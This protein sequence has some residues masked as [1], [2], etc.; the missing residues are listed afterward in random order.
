MLGTIEPR[1]NHALMIEVWERLAA[2]LPDELMPNL[3]IIG[4][5]GW[6]VEG[7]M[8]RLARHPLL[9]RSIHLHGPLPEAEVQA[10]LSRAVALLFPSLAEGFGYPPIE[11]ALAG[12]LPI[13]SDLPVFTKTLGHS[14]VYRNV[15]DAYS[16]SETIKKHVLG[17]DVLPV[18]PPPRVTSWAEHHE[19]V[20]RAIGGIVGKGRR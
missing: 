7:L 16:W 2:D 13:C 15:N 1:K 17:T 12:A 5:T 3:H 14:A 6:R 20:T 8:Q 4:P 10:H 19:A 18:L 9:G 11:A